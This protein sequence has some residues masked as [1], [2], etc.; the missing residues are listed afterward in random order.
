MRNKVIIAL[1]LIFLLLSAGSFIYINNYLLPVKVKAILTQRLSDYLKINVEIKGL[2]YNPL[3]GL[4]LDE[5]IIFDKTKDKENLYLKVKQISGNF[6]ILPIFREKKVI[7]P[8]LLIESPQIYLTRKKDKTFNIS[9]FFKKKPSPQKKIRYSFLV[10]KII[11]SGGKCLFKDEY[12][13]PIYKNEIIDLKIGTEFGLPDKLNFLIEGKLPNIDKEILSD[14]S[15]SGVYVISKEKTES[16]LKLE[17]IPL[18]D[19]LPYLKVLPFSLSHGVI[20]KLDLK[21]NLLKD[22]ELNIKGKII[23]KKIELRK[24]KFALA[25]NIDIEPDLNYGLKRKK[26]SYQANFKLI[27]TNFSGLDFIKELTEVN[28]DITLQG[29]KLQT[30]NLKAKFLNSYLDIKGLLQDFSSAYVKLNVSSESIDLKDLVNFI[31]LSQEDLI[32]TGSCTLNMNIKGSLKK[33]PLEFNATS[34]ITSAQLKAPYLKEPLAEIKGKIGFANE[35]LLW[36]NISLLYKDINYNTSGNLV[37]FN[38]PEIDFD[39]ISEELELDSALKIKDKLIRIKNCSGAYR[40]TDFIVKGKIDTKI[41][42]NPLLDIQVK[43]NF[44][45]Q[46]VIGILPEKLN[47]NLKP[48]KLKGAGK[49]VANL[50]G[51]LKQIKDWELSINLTS[52]S[53][54]IYDLALDDLRIKLNQKNR[55]LLVEPISA[56]AYDGALN[57]N[58]TSNLKLDTP[59]FITKLNL[60]DVDIAKLKMHTKL[61]EKD[62]SGLLNLE[63]NLY[64]TQK[65][66]DSLRGVGYISI[67]DGKLWQLNLFK[68]LGE[69]LFLPAYEKIVFKNAEADFIIQDKN[70]LTQNA[71]L[72]SDS[73]NLLCRGKLGF[74]GNL[75]FTL[76]SEINPKLMKDSPDLRKFTSAILGNL[77]T[78]NVSGTLK[79]PEYK[80]V[81]PTQGIIEELKR[82]FIF[83]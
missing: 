43:S 53:L 72:G 80:T 69:F 59:V 60:S 30:D 79:K 1:L 42:D 10:Y 23:T 73:L 4:I 66:L 37:D 75:D 7:I 11:A 6:L 57:A 33:L 55:A 8:N 29:N 18:N 54:S 47:Q 64:F 74:E 82:F 63:A 17:N 81:A 71:F 14:I 31:P 52:P 35:Q 26:L 44:S 46:D 38:Q 32:L 51:K 68:G 36:E 49:L 48:L 83:R 28:G 15:L 77:I 40:E 76:S 12:I 2:K 27:Q 21:I 22:E 70:I 65:G 25:G 56:K 45:A 16:N 41:K 50:N 67:K 58:L 34:I 20:D 39:L 5:L 24:G 13:S 78:V 19:Y 9:E 3:K 61:K 62:I